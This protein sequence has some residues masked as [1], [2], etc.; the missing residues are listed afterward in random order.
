MIQSLLHRISVGLFLLGTFAY[1]SAQ[2]DI[3]FVP[4]AGQWDDF[5]EYRADLG[6]GVFWM[7][8]S[9]WT[10]WLAGSGYDDLW[11]HYNVEGDG[12]GAPE[13][14]ESH[15]WKVSSR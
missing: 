12:E 2:T 6:S 8:E 1:A 14:L 7:E 15:A 4:N 11:S 3:A 10:A 5:V 9:G 13:Y